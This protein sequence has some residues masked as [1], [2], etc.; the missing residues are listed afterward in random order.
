MSCSILD[1]PLELIA[2]IIA[3][4]SD[5]HNVYNIIRTSKVFHL[6]WLHHNNSI[7]H[8]V[9]SS[10]E[11]YLEGGCRLARVQERHLG[12]SDSSHLQRLEQNSRVARWMCNLYVEEVVAYMPSRLRRPYI[13]Y[14]ER[15]RLHEACYSVWTAVVLMGA[16]TKPGADPDLVTSFLD[17]APLRS[18]LRWA[19]FAHWMQRFAD[20]KRHVDVQITMLGCCMLGKEEMSRVWEDTMEKIFERW[21]ERYEGVVSSGTIDYPTDEAPFRRFFTIFDDFQEFVERIP[22]STCL[23]E[24]VLG[25]QI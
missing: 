13:S 16:S 21:T 24:D 9:L 3:A 19:E 1:L 20:Y 22:E 4:A 23:A 12:L 5:F 11:P 25:N 7:C 15:R 17:Q 18:L 14:S 8:G 6:A 2:S 10:C